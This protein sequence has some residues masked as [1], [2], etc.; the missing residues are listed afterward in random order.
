MAPSLTSHLPGL[1]GCVFQPV[2]S[3]PL[4]SWTQPSP[5]LS[6]AAT[7]SCHIPPAVN[8]T[9]TQANPNNRFMTDAPWCEIRLPSPGAMLLPKWDQGMSLSLGLDARVNADMVRRFG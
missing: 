3:L 7:F 6:W 9:A 1:C 5:D 4:K 2:R 8:T